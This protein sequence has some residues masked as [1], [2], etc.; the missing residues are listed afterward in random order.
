MEKMKVFITAYG[1]GH[2]TMAIPVIKELHRR[3]HETIPLALTTAGKVMAQE[4]LSHFRPIDF[5]D[6][7]DCQIRRY[8]E[9]LAA[10]HHTDGKG[11]SYEESIAYLGVSFKDLVREVGEEKAWALYQ[12][13]GLNAFCPVYFLA[14][15]LREISPDIVLATTSPRMEMAALR[16]AHKLNIPS[17][18]MVDLFAILELNWLSRLDNGDYLTVYSDKVKQ[19]LVAAGRPAGRVVITGNPAF[20]SLADETLLEKGKNFRKTR[21]VSEHEKLILWAEQPEPLDPELPRRVRFH[22]HEICRQHPEW[23]L[24]VRLHPSSTDPS[25]EVIPPGVLQSFSHE[26]LPILISACDAVVTLTS[27]VAMEALLIDKPVLVIQ[28]SPYSHLVD[29]T[30]DDGALIIHSLLET[31]QGLERLFYDTAVQR[32]LAERRSQLPKIGK[33]ASKICDLLEC[34]EVLAR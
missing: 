20:D 17:V 13:K 29:Y 19:R 34:P 10:F 33:A 18:C 22:L 1:G 14:G 16:A 11:I 2:V 27:T 31:K 12:E 25:K 9:K 4:R 24:I 5:I 30:E 7:Y 8:G 32:A 6:K 26:S 21:E 23:R 28:I 3:G 15:V